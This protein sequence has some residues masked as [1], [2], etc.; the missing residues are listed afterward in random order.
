MDWF[1]ATRIREENTFIII[2]FVIFIAINICTVL[3]IIDELKALSSSG[4]LCSSAARRLKDYIPGLNRHDVHFRSDIFFSMNNG[5]VHNLDC[6]VSQG[7][8]C[9]CINK[10]SVE[11]F[12]YL[13]E[14]LDSPASNKQNSTQVS[15]ECGARSCDTSDECVVYPRCIEI[16]QISPKDKSKTLSSNMYAKDVP[17]GI[18]P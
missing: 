17:C 16:V 15:R 18:E 6:C 8:S 12:I 10:E 13:G 3:F 14:A 5:R 11:H 2:A 4:I 7:S 1:Y 9:G